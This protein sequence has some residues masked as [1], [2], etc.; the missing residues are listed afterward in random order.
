M[1]CFTEFWN[2]SVDE[3]VVTIMPQ[4]I[5]MALQTAIKIF[6]KQRCP[7]P[8]VAVNYNSTHKILQSM[9]KGKAKANQEI[10]TESHISV[11]I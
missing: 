4:G 9:L 11:H 5:L 6:S 7:T 8:W 10:A 2:H 1:I 3:R